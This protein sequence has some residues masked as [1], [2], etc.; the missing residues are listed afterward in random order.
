MEIVEVEEAE[1]E[2]EVEMDLQLKDFVLEEVVECLMKVLQE[3]GVEEELMPLTRSNRKKRLTSTSELSHWLEELGFRFAGFLPFYR[4]AAH[5]VF[6]MHSPSNERFVISSELMEESILA[7]YLD[8]SG[9][10]EKA[11]GDA[12]KP[13]EIPFPPKSGRSPSQRSPSPRNPS[14][15]RPTIA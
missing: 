4:G 15:P 9:G 2:A 14:L 6:A 8:R 5:C 1:V 11:L 12:C 13:G 10:G 7:R 3:V